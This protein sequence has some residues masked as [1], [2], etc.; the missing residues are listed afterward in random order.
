MNTLE[1]ILNA[2]GS[3]KPFLDKIIIDEDGR[4]QPFTKGGVKAYEK[5]TEILYAVGEL[6]NTNMNDIVE[7]LDSIA[8]QDMQEVSEMVRLRQYRMVEGIGSHWNKRWVIQEKYKYYENGEWVYSWY[9]VFWSSDKV[10]C[11]EVFE[12]YKAEINER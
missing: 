8:N 12:K 4:R 6:T 2:L 5:L 7:E 1:N 9:L 3:K 11:E 10:K